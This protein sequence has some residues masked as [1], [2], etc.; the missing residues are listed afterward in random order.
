MPITRSQQ[1]E[2]TRRAIIQAA[3]NQLSADK[4]FASISLREVAREADIAPA[5]FY[6]HFKDMEELG[7][8]LVDEC[9]LALRQLMRKARK[10]FAEGG[11]VINT[12]VETFME[13][14]EQNPNIFRLLFHERSG[15]AFALRSAVGREIQ[16][17]I[18]ELADYLDDYN[19]DKSMA[20][21]Q[22]EAMVAVVFNA[23]AESL[24]A[25]PSARKAIS[26]RAMIQLRFI[27]SGAH[28]AAKKKGNL[29][30]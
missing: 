28:E 16:Y 15:T 21:T 27:A 1:K 26:E 5:S 2:K 9:G 30:Q 10:R 23:G 19:S 25:K 17:F 22:A 11:S 29:D 7:L 20:Y 12:S 14:T 3:L 8:T 6:R 24:D 13:F 4:S 18:A